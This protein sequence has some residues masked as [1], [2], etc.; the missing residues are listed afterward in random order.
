MTSAHK[1]SLFPV[2]CFFSSSTYPQKD[3]A[4][5]YNTRPDSH[6]DGTGL[7]FHFVFAKQ[8]H[9][10]ILT[11]YFCFF[12]FFFHFS[13]SFL[14]CFPPTFSPFPMFFFFFSFFFWQMRW[15]NESQSHKKNNGPKHSRV[16]APRPPRH[17]WEWV[18]HTHR[19]ASLP[20]VTEGE[21]QHHCTP[22]WSTGERFC[23]GLEL[24]QLLQES[25]SLIQPPPLHTPG[26]PPGARIDLQV[27]SFNRLAVANATP[28]TRTLRGRGN[29]SHLT[30]DTIVVRSPIER[31]GRVASHQRPPPTAW[32]PDENCG[33]KSISRTITLGAHS[34]ACL[35]ADT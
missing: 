23:S 32:C 35:A 18:H 16:C 27:L 26:P 6:M 9:F 5:L 17:G 19:L 20:S 11:S 21:L 10:V 4:Q 14:S 13:L 34:R 31:R 3:T 22:T 8:E 25:L 2:V 28:S 24:H 29:P 12:S 15:K 1:H 7:E 30:A 33:S